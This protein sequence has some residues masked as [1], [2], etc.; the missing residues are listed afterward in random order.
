MTQKKKKEKKRKI[1]ESLATPRI[2]SGI[3]LSR[4]FRTVETFATNV[5][6]LRR[7]STR[8]NL[9]VNIL[10]ACNVNVVSRISSRVR[11][12]Q[13]VI[14]LIT[15]LDESR[16]PNCNDVPEDLVYS[17]HRRLTNLFT[18]TRPWCISTCFDAR[19]FK[20]TN[21]ESLSCREYSILRD[22]F[23][24]TKILTVFPSVSATAEMVKVNHCRRSF[25]SRGRPFER[26]FR[27]SSLSILEILEQAATGKNRLE[28]RYRS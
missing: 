14:L 6:H 11:A 7:I 16:S 28:R 9:F 1:E 15:K 26:Q 21:I 3:D 18:A 23:A 24:A 20:Y 13:S 10:L 5:S 17:Q 25:S 12:R 2:V 8:G 19:N 4:T 27:V 22:V